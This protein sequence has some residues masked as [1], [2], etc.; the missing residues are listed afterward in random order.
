[1]FTINQRLICKNLFFSDSKEIETSISIVNSK[2]KISTKVINSLRK[3]KNPFFKTEIP[4]LVFS[5]KIL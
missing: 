1:M 4:Q 5:K 3:P 2:P